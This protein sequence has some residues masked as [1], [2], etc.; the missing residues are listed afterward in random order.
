V[1]I[2]RFFLTQKAQEAQE[3]QKRKKIMSLASFAFIFLISVKQ[4]AFE[5]L[6]VIPLKKR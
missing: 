3:A 1:L 5:I 2:G 4:A 6:P